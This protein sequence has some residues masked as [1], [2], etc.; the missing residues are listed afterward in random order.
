LLGSGVTLGCG[1]LAVTGQVPGVSLTDPD[2]RAQI[3]ELHERVA[4][5]RAVSA[6]DGRTLA[7]V[8]ELRA[9]LDAMVAAV[10]SIDETVQDLVKR[11]QDAGAVPR[12]NPATVEVDVESKLDPLE[13]RLAALEREVDALNRAQT[14][15]VS[16]AR[17]AALTLALTNLKRAISDGRPFAAEL[18]AV[19]NLS[20]GRLPVAQLSVYKDEGVPSLAEL[21]RAFTSSSQQ[22]IQAHYQSKSD[23][24]MGD[25]LSRAKAAIQV[26]PADTSGDTVEA[27][28][29]RM[30]TQLRSGNVAAAVAESE[31]LDAAAKEAMKPWLEKARRRA[32]AD[33]AIRKTDRELLASLT[34]APSKR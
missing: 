28:I 1:Y 11:S 21:E 17:T 30:E 16:D 31:G 22:A 34:R 19:D 7:D 8:N 33:E 24:F 14:E 20:G 12:V 25:V 5:L 2:T 4:A 3:R 13:K 15:H 23:S 6:G 27:V 10:H 32:A 26:R 29:G 18:A 9:R